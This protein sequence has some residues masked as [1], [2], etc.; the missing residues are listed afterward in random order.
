MPKSAMDAARKA[1][2]ILLGAMG[3]PPSAIPM[4]E[5]AP[6]LDLRFE[7]GLF[8][9]VRPVRTLPSMPAILA[10]K[11]AAHLDFIVIREST[12]ASSPRAARVL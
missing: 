5:I 7:F 12:G 3:W 1:D 6:Q 2:A 8:A 9:G 4:A 10:D 11:R